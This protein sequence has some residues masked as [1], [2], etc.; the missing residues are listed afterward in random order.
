MLYGQQKSLTMDRTRIQEVVYRI[1][2]SRGYAAH[3]DLWSPGYFSVLLTSSDPVTLVASS[4]SWDTIRAV[5]PEYAN[6]AE[7]IRRK[8]LLTRAVSVPDTGPAAEL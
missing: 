2:E 7:K 3:G 4:E 6:G 8:R 5:T 1:E